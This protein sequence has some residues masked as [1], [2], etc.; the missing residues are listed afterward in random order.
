MQVRRI[1]LPRT[2]VNEA[3]TAVLSL[4][5]LALANRVVKQRP[6]T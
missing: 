6:D 5:V 1:N 3:G 2:L 4:R